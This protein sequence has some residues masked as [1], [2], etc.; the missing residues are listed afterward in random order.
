MAATIGSQAHVWTG[1]ERR[2]ADQAVHDA[3]GLPLERVGAKVFRYGWR[4]S[5]CGPDC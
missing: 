5:S 4:S 1:P 2:A 3:A